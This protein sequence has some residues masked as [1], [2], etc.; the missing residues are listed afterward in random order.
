MML[1]SM[2]LMS[3]RGVLWDPHRYDQVEINVNIP[4]NKPTL[5]LEH[6]CKMSLSLS[7]SL[8]I[9]IYLSRVPASVPVHDNTHSNARQT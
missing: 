1:A 6:G 3:Y 7:L 5:G 2:V 8:V 9:H 4:S